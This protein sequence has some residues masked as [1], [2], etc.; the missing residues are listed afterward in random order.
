MA[1]R[2]LSSVSGTSL[3][4]NLPSLWSR[5]RKRRRGNFEVNWSCGKASVKHMGQ[6]RG[7]EESEGRGREM[8]C[9]VK[10]SRGSC[11][12]QDLAMRFLGVGPQLIG[13]SLY[14]TPFV[15]S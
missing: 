3:S 5:K 12:K 7:A 10:Y 9:E 8:P 6:R 11:G 13:Q 15:T 1:A 4:R 14:E 2:D